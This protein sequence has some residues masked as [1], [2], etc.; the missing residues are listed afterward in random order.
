MTPTRRPI[1][2]GSTPAPEPRTRDARPL[3]QHRDERPMRHL[4]AD[5]DDP[6][7][8][9]RCDFPGIVAVIFIVVAFVVAVSH[10]PREHAADHPKPSS[11]K[12][13]SL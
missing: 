3:V 2:P 8:F 11:L 4:S 6:D 7:P 12:P 13:G 10:L 5:S 1:Y 9:W